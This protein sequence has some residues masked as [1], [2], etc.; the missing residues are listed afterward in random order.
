M[1]YKQANG[2]WAAT[3]AATVQ[4]S[5]SQTVTFNSAG[6]ELGDK[7][8]VRLTL[9]VTA[10][11]GTSPTLDVTMETSQDNATWTSLGTFAQKTTTGSEFKIFSGC[12]RFVRAACTIGGTT[13]DFTFS[14]AGEAV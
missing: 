5:A 9:D 6:L 4:A 12:G 10:A 11:T 1:G 13:P 8:T 2:E 3:K 14:I 7:G